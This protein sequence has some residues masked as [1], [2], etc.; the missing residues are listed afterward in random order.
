MTEEDFKVNDINVQV[1][2]L[3]EDL[4]AI[5]MRS[6]PRGLEVVEAI[7]CTLEIDPT[8]PVMNFNTRPFNWK[9][10]SGELAW[11]LK[12]DSSVNFIS[13]FS[14][15]WNKLKNPNGSI[16]SN[17]GHILFQDHPGSSY[18]EN[19]REPVNQ[20]QW[21]YDSLKKDPFSRQAVAF[22]S[23]PYYQFKD[24]KDFVCTFYLNFWIRKDY[25]DMKVQ[26]R[27]NDIFFGLTYDAPWF[28]LIQQSMY[29][30]LKKLYP[31]LKLG[32]Y[33]HSA[34]NIHYYERHYSLVDEI[35]S[36][37]PLSS[38]K[39]ILKFPLFEYKNDIFSITKEAQ[40]YIDLVEQNATKN[41]SNEEWKKILSFLLEIA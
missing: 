4:N 24:N 34:D 15:F 25:L 31:N 1:Y 29:M 10:F 16:N 12:K 22:L 14:T 21:V 32:M 38:E 19:G 35:L 5:G 3:L 40:E 8:L 2:H 6:N 11:Y 33:Y 30:N 9:Y 13:N 41:L 7:I 17:Y 39:L 27:S 37:S 28:S 23:S 26:M 18:D 20:M 36:S